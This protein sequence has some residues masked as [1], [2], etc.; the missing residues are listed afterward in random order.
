MQIHASG[1]VLNV[2]VG[3]VFGPPDL[4][5]LRDAFAALGPTSALTVDFSGVRTCDDASLA[6]LAQALTSC[7]T[8]EVELRGLTEHQWSLLT[9]LGLHPERSAS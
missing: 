1:G 3:T 2:R 8:G 5:R 6:Q 4:A 9:Y 7:S